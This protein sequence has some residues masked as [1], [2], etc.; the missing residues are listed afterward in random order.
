[1]LGQE[2]S[3]H[4]QPWPEYD[5]AAAAAEELEIPVQVNG[6]VRDRLIVPAD[7]A[8]EQLEEL[9]LASEKVQAHVAGKT[10][11]KV[12]VVPGKLVSG[13]AG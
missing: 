1:M 7:T 5:P 8:A 4:R 12:L 3:V 2:G 10:V 6:K 9:A 11:R 13:V